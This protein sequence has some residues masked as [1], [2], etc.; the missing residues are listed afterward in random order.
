MRAVYYTAFKQAP[1]LAQLPDPT[2]APDA[3]V[4]QVA[5]SGLCRSDWHGWCGHDPDIHLPHVP[6]HELAGVV[7]AVGKDVKRWRGGERVTVPFVGGCGH[8]SVCAGGQHQVCPSQFQPGFTHWG[9]FAEYVAIHYADT[10]LVALPDRLDFVTAASLGC[11]FATSFRAVTAQ[12]QVQGGEWVV[13]HGCGGVGLS[14]LMI[15]QALG[16]RCIAVD[17]HAGQ[18]ALAQE[19]GAEH[20]L[21]PQQLDVVAAIQ[22]ITHGGAQVSIDALG[23]TE[24]CRNSI[25]CLGIQ[26]RHVQVGLLVGEHH[27][28]RIPMERVIGRELRLLGSHGLQAHV[29]PQMLGM[30]ASGKLA[31]ERLIGRRLS[32]DQAP[33]ALMALGEMRDSGIA[34]IDRF[35][36]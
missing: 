24:T 23:S 31:P 32:L 30:I 12:A 3:V 26:G 2:P 33:A 15:A 6:G 13:I 35:V 18:L 29:Y 17:V 28:P 7:V 8:C 10:N 36:P 20:C 19:L 22:D 21:N 34:I 9:S 14:A 4:V 5:A 16:A 1:E 25:L 11:R 27:Q